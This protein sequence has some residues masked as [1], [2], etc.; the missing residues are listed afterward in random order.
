MPLARPS[1]K[2]RRAAII[3]KRR[4]PE[5]EE[6]SAASSSLAAAVPKYRY[7]SFLYPIMELHG[8][9][10]LIG[11]SKYSAARSP[12]RT[13][14]RSRRQRYSRPPSPP[15]PLSPLLPIILPYLFPRSWTR[16][17]ARL[18]GPLPLA[19]GRPGPLSTLSD[20]TA[21]TLVAEKALDQKS[22]GS[23]KKRYAAK[24]IPRG[25]SA[26]ILTTKITRTTPPRRSPPL[27]FGRH[28]LIIFFSLFDQKPDQ[29]HRSDRAMP[30]PPAEDPGQI[31][32]VPAPSSVI[33]SS[34]PSPFPT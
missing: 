2:G 34:Y 10:R 4:K 1:P 29:P 21:R 20:F 26:L 12:C 3:Q 24:R 13:A 17:F 9:H 27:V 11:K 32:Q 14:E 25:T 6:S 15:Q 31:P 23:A 30:G 8:V 22:Q 19:P 33:T 18:S 16:L 7:L 5:R 28:F